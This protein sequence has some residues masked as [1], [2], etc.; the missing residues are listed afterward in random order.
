LLTLLNQLGNLSK[1]EL[2][3]LRVDES[4][5]TIGWV[6]SFDNK[7][8]NATISVG[9]FLANLPELKNGEF[10]DKIKNDSIDFN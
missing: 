10:T 9:R 2:N 7:D 8:W 4:R 1:E 6:H 5:N 3:K